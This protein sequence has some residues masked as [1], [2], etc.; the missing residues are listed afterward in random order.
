[1]MNNL[2]NIDIRYKILKKM[3][4]H[5]QHKTYSLSL[6]KYFRSTQ[7]KMLPQLCVRCLL[8]GSFSLVGGGDVV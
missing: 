4:V 2:D 5:L 8:C 1:M 6:T 7:T 3:H